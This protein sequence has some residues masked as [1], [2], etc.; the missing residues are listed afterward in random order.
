MQLS[1]PSFWKNQSDSLSGENGLRTERNSGTTR[2]TLFWLAEE[3]AE[4]LIRAEAHVI[5]KIA[6]RNVH[7]C[8]RLLGAHLSVQRIKHSHDY[9]GAH[10]YQETVGHSERFQIRV[11]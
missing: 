11:G 8:C 7:I 2:A 9:N 6:C 3:S 10:V 1:F 5:R 4:E